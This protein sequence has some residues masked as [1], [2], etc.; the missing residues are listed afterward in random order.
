M[1]EE[2]M[3]WKTGDESYT[4]KRLIKITRLS[5]LTIRNKIIHLFENGLISFIDARPREVF[6]TSKGK[7]TRERSIRYIKCTKI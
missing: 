2:L 3:W 4:E 5:R 7:I 1:I 6:L